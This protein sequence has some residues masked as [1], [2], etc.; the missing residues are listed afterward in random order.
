MQQEA[1]L[2]CSNLKSLKGEVQSKGGFCK[3]SSIRRALRGSCRI[4][5]APPGEV[6]STLS[7]HYSATHSFDPS[8]FSSKCRLRMQAQT[9]TS[10]DASAKE[11]HPSTGG[12]ELQLSPPLFLAYIDESSASEETRKYV[13]QRNSF[14][15][16]SDPASD[17]VHRGKESLS[18]SDSSV[19]QEKAEADGSGSSTSS[20]D[21]SN[22]DVSISQWMHPR[23]AWSAVQSLGNRLSGRFSPR[24]R[25]LFLL[26]ILTFLYGK[27]SSK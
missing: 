12:V 7:R 6:A 5:G 3:N 17:T 13:S 1:R 8:R 19:H 23:S 10:C 4:H 26:N 14:E 20:R 21:S 2:T 11:S 18:D 22:S 27:N 25:G 9:K 16:S 15:S 24:I